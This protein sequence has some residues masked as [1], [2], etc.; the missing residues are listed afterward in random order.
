MFVHFCYNFYIFKAFPNS[1]DLALIHGVIFRFP[2]YIM[3][4]YA[5]LA[6]ELVKKPARIPSKKFAIPTSQCLHIYKNV[7]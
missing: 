5:P 7:V 6:V 2:T 1:V 3:A 4:K